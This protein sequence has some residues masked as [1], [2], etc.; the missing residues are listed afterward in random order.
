M[1][2]IIFTE[3]LQLVEDNFGYD[4]V[5]EIL[6]KTELPSNGVYTSVGTY[7]HIEILS[8]ASNL[9]K[10][11]GIPLNDLLV[12]YGK[13][14]FPRLLKLAGELAIEYHSTF[15]LLE[16]LDS[17][18]HVEVLKLYP[19]AELPKFLVTRHTKTELD[20]IYSSCRPFAYLAKGL[21]EGCITHYQEDIE[22]S[23]TNRDTHMEFNSVIELTKR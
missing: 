22:I 10:I 20:L 8:L 3:F 14:L 21:I 12:I 2:G 13:Y 7:N 1:K 17:I 23:L 5:D 16:S 19:E 18:I 9:E 6:Q 4:V 11:S 15:E